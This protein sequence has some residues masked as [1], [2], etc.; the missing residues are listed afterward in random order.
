MSDTERSSG[1]PDAGTGAAE[2]GGLLDLLRMAAIVLDARGRIVLW[3]PPAESLFGY[4]AAEALGQYAGR[5]LVA[6][7]HF[8]LVLRL[9][10]E[11]MRTG[12]SWAGTFPMRHK[13]GRTR[14]LEFRNMRLQNDEG[15]YY[16]LGLCAEQETLRKIEQ[17]VALSMRL[18]EQSPI[19]LAVLDPDLRYVAVN[20][21]L[22]RI[23][24][25]PAERRLGRRIGEVL[26][27]VDAEEAEILRR[28]LDSGEPNLNREIVGRIPADP[29]TDHAW[30]V[31]LFRLDTAGG[32]VL[33]VAVSVID[34]TDRH[35]AALQ[36]EQARH[37][38]SMV[39]EAAVRIGTTLD[40]ERT[41]RELA[42]FVV[43]RLADIAAVDVLDTV[44]GGAGR[45]GTGRAADFRALAVESACP[46]V[47]VDAADR[48]GDLAQYGAD[49]L[50]TRCVR[51][52]RPAFVPHVRPDDLTVIARDAR[53]AGQLA[54]AGVHSYLA[55]PLI[56]R[57]EVLGVLDLKRARSPRPFSDEDV[58][59]ATELAARAAVCIDNARWY[60]RQRDTALTLQRSM[61]PRAPASQRGLEFAAR[62][63]PAG[64]GFEVGG[65]WFDV[66]PRRDELT[67][68]VVGDV[69]GSGISAATTMGRLR[70]ATQTL[71]KLA[72]DPADVL[73]HL[74]EITAEMDSLIA[75]CVY[76]VYDPYRAECCMA[77]AGH[78]PPVVVRAGAPRLID[79]P[80]GAPLGTGTASY[81]AV[82]LPLDTGDRLV[83]YT[84]GLIERRREDIDSR[85]QVLL[86]LLDTPG[87]SLEDMCDHLLHALRNP[88][89]D[90]DVALLIASPR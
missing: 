8:G 37:R 69:K 84:D 26:E 49:R 67:A 29:D 58:L 77:R 56:A 75:T 83:L 90:D 20:A 14:L 82:T 65:D 89:D 71:T 22:E 30:S 34:I 86:R 13:D 72:L 10:D 51:T 27:F 45:S 70:T 54:E 68:L 19:G 18:V 35:R 41:A 4:T 74:D 47:A 2:P 44:L 55:V 40:L 9:F 5:L 61:L 43:P 66:I 25:I 81:R 11:V 32:K 88:D 1:F 60:R 6:E 33:G 79:L 53:A 39:A 16:A 73:T 12:E 85:L 36:A 21:A 62:Y 31:S 59:L 63:Q 80:S 64:T 87:T 15:D 42:E 78:L 24:G 3:S 38:L 57:G 28:V 50:V 48:P 23:D 46:T 52:A 76:A 7:E 17:D